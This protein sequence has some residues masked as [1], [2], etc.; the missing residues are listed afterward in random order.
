[1]RTKTLILAAVLGVAGVASS[2]AQVY[3]VNAVG[4]VNLSFANAGFYII[5][6]P[7]NNGNNQLGTILPNPPDNT[8]VYKFAGGVFVEGQQFI[9]GAGGGWFNSLGASTTTLAPG[10]GAFIQI[11]AGL[12]YPVTLTFV[13]DVPQGTAL[14]QPLP[15][16]FSLQASQVPIS[17]GLSTIGNSGMNFPAVDNDLVYFFNG[18]A[19]SYVEG[20]QFIAGAGGGWFNSSGA[21]DPTPAV[22]QGFFLLRTGTAGSWTRSFDVN[23]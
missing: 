22:G 4:Y 18:A 19:Q 20:I 15:Q 11:P 10:E 13:G 6:N 2:L 7:L 12:T 5:A 17:A 1:M 8:L 9:A 23:L 3:S 21:A 14:T 16:G